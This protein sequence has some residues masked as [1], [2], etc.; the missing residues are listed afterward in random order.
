MRW[1]TLCGVLLAAVLG[2]VSQ[3]KAEAPYQVEWTAQLGS[4][5]D[6][7]SYSVAVDS[8]GATYLAGYTRGNLAGTNRGGF[9][10]WLAKFDSSGRELWRKQLGSSEWDFCWSVVVDASGSISA[11]GRTKG[12][13]AGHNQGDYDA[14]L[15]KFDGR[16]ALL[17][18]NQIGTTRSDSS[19]SLAV[20]RAGAVYVAGR[21]AGDLA[22]TN[23][24]L[25]DVWLAKFDSAGAEVWRKQLGSNA[26][27]HTNSIAVGS[28]GAIYVTG[29]TNGNFAGMHLGEDDGWLAKFDPAG[30]LL[31]K[32][33]I[34]T[35]V[36]E[37]SMSVAVD[38]AGA[39]YVAGY[40]EGNLAGTFRGGNWDAWLAKF[41]SA[42]VVVWKTQLGTKRSDRSY[43]VAV[44]SA[45]A[46]YVTG[47][48]SGDLAGANQGSWDAWLAKF[49]SMGD[50]LWRKQFSSG[51]IDLGY[52]VAVGA[53]GVYV[54]G[55]T[56]GD[57]AGT[58]QGKSDAF[59]VKLIAI[60]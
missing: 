1:F 34:G 8:E 28:D 26:T 38:S 52:S 24:G 22:G 27:D 31:W 20:D 48:T 14:W 7:Y 29:G 2:T 42:G 10:A 60:P 16:G 3:V 57:L 32:T 18:K 51:Q 12:D 56:T 59:L 40:T 36:E 30:E 4:R 53:E 46:V 50:E 9:D 44:N 33:Q 5:H 39:V 54:T 11:T 17:W 23:Q 21:T 13:L 58:N 19:R 55:H 35:I 6:D 15:A 49:D 43:A 37:D 45:D 41:N 47:K 25:Y